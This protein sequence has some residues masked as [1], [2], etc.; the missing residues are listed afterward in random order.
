MEKENFQQHKIAKTISEQI[1]YLHE[2]KRIQ[3]NDMLESE[4]KDKL[5]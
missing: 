1:E 2:N 3:F 4:A 5:L